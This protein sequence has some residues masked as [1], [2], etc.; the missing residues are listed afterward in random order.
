MSR[1]IGVLAHSSA[2]APLRVMGLLP[3][4]R[5]PA[6]PV[7]YP[8][9][10]RGGGALFPAARTPESAANANRARGPRARATGPPWRVE[11][12]RFPVPRRVWRA[13]LYLGCTGDALPQS[14]AIRMSTHC[15]CHWG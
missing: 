9:A 5:F 12:R 4:P 3:R 6:F 13:W 10:R 1:R 11:E 14:R 7:R 15:Q 8:S 2:A